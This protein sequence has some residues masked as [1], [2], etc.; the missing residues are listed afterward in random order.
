[1]RE[2]E[3]VM[4]SF[5][6]VVVFAILALVI[7][8]CRVYA[9]DEV[10]VQDGLE[11]VPP[12][13]EQMEN[14][15]DTG[16]NLIADT[17]GETA[18][19]DTPKPVPVVNEATQIDTVMDGNN[20]ISIENMPSLFFTFWQHRSI[21]D[22]KNKRGV[23]RPPTQAELE[24]LENG[25]SLILEPEKR[26]ITLGGIVFKAEGDWT[27]WLNGERVTPTAVPEEVLDLR[28]YKDY[29]E[30]KWIDNLTNQIFP[31]RLR[32]HQSFNLDQRI[33]LPG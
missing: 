10:N 17:A 5:Y 30:V 7:S 21:I 27:I 1:M 24:A 25:E 18:V 11:N 29:I 2:G 3:K 32:A 13:P 8:P 20:E 14:S 16:A 31:L 33:F 23:V 26:D 22:A 6:I 9:Q 4:K 19:V 12:E 28:V 15:D